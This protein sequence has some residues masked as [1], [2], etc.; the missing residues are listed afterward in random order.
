MEQFLSHLELIRENPFMVDYTKLNILSN[1]QR[2]IQF[3]IKQGRY[4]KVF[5][6]PI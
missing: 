1:T 2:R 5:P 4:K 3:S 6:P